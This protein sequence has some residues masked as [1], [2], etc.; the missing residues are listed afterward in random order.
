MSAVVER[1]AGLDSDDDS[2]SSD[3]WL[4]EEEREVKSEVI[5]DYETDDGWLTY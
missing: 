1:I 4:M 2:D 3:E 5:V